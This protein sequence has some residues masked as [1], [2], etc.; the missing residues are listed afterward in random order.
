MHS[1]DSFII[2]IPN[3]E[4]I[5]NV[6]K[7]HITTKKLKS[8]FEFIKINEDLLLKLCKGVIY[9]VDFTKRFVKCNI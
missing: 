5:G 6:N 7:E 8:I 9:I 4:I 2:T 1:E 3:L